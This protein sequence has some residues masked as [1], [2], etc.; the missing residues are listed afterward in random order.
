MFRPLWVP[1]AS[2]RTGRTTE[3]PQ[4]YTAIELGTSG[5]GTLSDVCGINAS[6]QV[7]G[8]PHLPQVEPPSAPYHARPANIGP[9]LT[10]TKRATLET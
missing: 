5:R 4:Q 7:T 2:L 3:D 8:Y 1:T 9:S 6:G 10:L